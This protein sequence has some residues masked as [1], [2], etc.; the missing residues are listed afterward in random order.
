MVVVVCLSSSLPSCV[1]VVTV[2]TLMTGGRGPARAC[3]ARPTL[4]PLPGEAAIA[5]PAPPPPAPP[6]GGSRGSIPSRRPRLACSCE[7]TTRAHVSR[8]VAAASV[9]RGRITSRACACASRSPE[10]EESALC[11]RFREATPREILRRIRCK[12]SLGARV[13]AHVS[14][15]R[16]RTMRGGR[17][18]SAPSVP[19]EVRVTELALLAVLGRFVEVVPAQTHARQKQRGRT[20]R[21]THGLTC[22]A[23]VRT[24]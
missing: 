17:L 9:Y 11:C 10:E 16:P 23:A 22:S 15:G 4:Y 8:R 13:S 3:S 2:V 18:G 5:T 24:S 1:V 20:T 19:L 21:H 7:R 14:S 12:M 6:P